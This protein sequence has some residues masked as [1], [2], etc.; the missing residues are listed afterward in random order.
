MGT[1]GDGDKGKSGGAPTAGNGAAK[2]AGTNTGAGTNATNANKLPGFN[3]D[4]GVAYKTGDLKA[5]GTE[6]G[7][8]STTKQNLQGHPNFNLPSKNE[9][10][11]NEYRSEYEIKESIKYGEEQN[12][13]TPR[14][15]AVNVLNMAN[16]IGDAVDVYKYSQNGLD[17]KGHPMTGE[18]AFF[19][20]TGLAMLFTP[21]KFSGAANM[22]TNTASKELVV[23]T[24]ETFAQAAFKESI[25]MAEKIGPYTINGTK[26]LVGET[27]N[28]NIFLLETA[29]S[30]KSLAGFRTLLN[31]MESEAL[32]S[33]ANKI[34]IFGSSVINEGFLNPTVAARFGYSFEKSGSGVY[35]QKVLK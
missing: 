16:P 22:A 13:A 25:G 33:G 27:F 2:A 31:S 3:P 21:I 35:F 18:Q 1:D 11:Y 6:G 4:P 20:T 30:S 7:G 32:S 14:A 5:A 23:L 19:K 12:W 15:V 26:G 8:G 34:S 28:R 10:L 17:R 29:K 24:N 9:Q